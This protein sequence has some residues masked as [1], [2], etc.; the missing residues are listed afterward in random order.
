MRSTVGFGDA[1]VGM[2]LLCM[3]IDVKQASPLIALV[4]TCIG[5]MI[6]LGSWR[7]IHFQSARR[8]ILSAFC[9]IPF[10][11]MF[12]KGTN[13]AVVNGILGVIVVSFAG[14]SLWKPQMTELKNDRW[15]WLFGVFAGFLGGAYNT[16]GPPLVIYGSLRRWTAVEFRATLQG[17][18]LPTGI[19]VIASHAYDGLL[20]ENVTHTFWLALPVAIVAML[21]GG[22]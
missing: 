7:D 6:L 1:L 17:Y 5:G 12:L 20:V 15:A 16:H 4:S 2:P 19:M 14:Y 3:F 9:G 21:I 13:E 18:F 10:G 8:L 22:D 11:V